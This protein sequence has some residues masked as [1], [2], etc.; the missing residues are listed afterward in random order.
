M[1][2]FLLAFLAVYGSANGYLFWKVCTA[3]AKLGRFRILLAAF[4]GLMVASPVLARFL[5][6][7][8]YARP[9]SALGLAGYCWM[10]VTFW[11]IALGV[12][13]DLWNLAVR[14]VAL[15]APGRPARCCCRPGRR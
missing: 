6:A 8:G 7:R 5:D 4:L 10:A 12:T 14:T 9:A 15:A 1:W 3:F 2:F 13:T 11:F